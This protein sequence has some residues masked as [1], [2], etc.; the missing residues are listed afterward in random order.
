MSNHA[1]RRSQQRGIPERYADIIIEYGIAKRKPGNVLEYRLQRKKIDQIVMQFKHF[2][3][4][5]DKC[6]KKG[7]LVDSNTRKIIT[8]YNLK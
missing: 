5:L 3:Q 4:S 8:V 2:I 7:V 1:I 6:T